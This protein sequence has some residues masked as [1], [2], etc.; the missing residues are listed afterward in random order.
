MTY[1]LRHGNDIPVFRYGK[2]RFKS[3]DRSPS[4]LHLA[5]AQV[6]LNPQ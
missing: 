6:I 2:S 3:M 4:R 1:N 5:D